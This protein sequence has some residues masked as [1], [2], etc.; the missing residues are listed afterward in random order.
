MKHISSKYG[1][2]VKHTLGSP[3]RWN[4]SFS[5]QNIMK[6]MMCDFYIIRNTLAL[7]LFVQNIVCILVVYIFCTQ[8]IH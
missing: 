6:M 5:P 4:L 2:P 1:F 3:F 8:I 7:Y